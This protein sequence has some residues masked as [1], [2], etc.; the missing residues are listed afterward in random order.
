MKIT[1]R[2][3]TYK[4]FIYQF[5]DQYSQN[6]L[7]SFWLPEEVNMQSDIMDWQM[8][9]TDSEKYLISSILKSFTQV[10]ILI[11]DYWRNV[12]NWFPHPEIAQAAAIMSAFE[13]I[14]QR[15][16][17][18]LNDTLGINNFSEFLTDPVSK[19]KVDNWV[20]VKTKNIEDI[21]RSLAVFSGFGE[22]VSLFSSFAILLNFSRFNKLKGVGQ[23]ISWSIRDE[24]L[25]SEFGC[26]LF[27][28]VKEEFPDIWTD[29]FK[30][31]L[32]E[33]ARIVVKIEDDF[34]DQA[35]S[36][37]AGH[38]EGLDSKD[39]K[40]FIRHR[41]NT[42]LKDLGLKS[43]W[44]NIDSDSVNRVTSWFEPLSAGVE[45]ADFFAM[46]PSAYSRG[47]VD[48]SKIWEN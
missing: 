8:V 23:I 25:H 39:L 34:I 12:A 32:Y 47:S 3:Q 6:S 22:G 36:F 9:L 29:E 27:N 21:A 26:R 2:R 35:F 15:A 37:S 20:L 48:F 40:Q 45:H 46:Q 38:V 14:H 7:R 10:E 28:Q 43:N 5:A 17:A 31:P 24:S 44:K 33:A 42:K 1:H 11:G 19:A 4:P 30:K 13:S 16:Y 18:H 41:A